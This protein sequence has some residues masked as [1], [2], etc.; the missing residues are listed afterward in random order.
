M[1][2]IMKCLKIN[3]GSMMLHYID[4]KK[5]TVKA[6]SSIAIHAILMHWIL[7]TQLTG[8]V[9]FEVLLMVEIII[10]ITKKK[11]SLHSLDSPIY[12]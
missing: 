2:L 9:F 10:I 3:S 4:K 6:V 1:N 5:N 11:T 7:Y 12:Q 8:S